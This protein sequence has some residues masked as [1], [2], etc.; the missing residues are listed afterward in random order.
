MQQNILHYK[1][2]G[3]GPVLIIL[4][5]LFGSLDNWQGLAKK[6]AA[7]FRVIT[8]DLRNHGRSFHHPIHDYEAM[9]D[10]ILNLMDF[11]NV[12]K[13]HF[14]GHSMG[15]KVAMY[16]ALNNP[17]R[18]N[19]L[20]ICDITAAAYEDRH[21]EVF[22]ALQTAPLVVSDRQT[23]T[24]YLMI[25]LGNEKSTVL[26]LMKSLMRDLS[27][28]GFQWRFNLDTLAGQYPLISAGLSS[29]TAYQGAVLFLKGE[30][31]DYISAE[32]YFSITS[33]FPN[34][35]LEEIRGAGHWIHADQPDLFFEVCMSFLLR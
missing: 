1:E 35:E 16:L 15:G 17:G 7:N 29:D 19:R 28:K 30:N 5:G 14:I 32:T 11:L 26:F 6:F 3:N 13:A 31:S 21:H 9:S 8:P 24:D 10:D 4:H 23:V 25:Q 12:G 20:I 22:D 27:G 2:Q 34:H 18:I 33:I